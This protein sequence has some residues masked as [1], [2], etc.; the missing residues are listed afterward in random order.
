M[1]IKHFIFASVFDNGHNSVKLKF[2]YQSNI[3]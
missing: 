1:G 3:N 2:I